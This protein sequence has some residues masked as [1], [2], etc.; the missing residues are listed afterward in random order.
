M[1]FA[2]VWSIISSL[3]RGL[4]HRPGAQTMLYLSLVNFEIQ[5]SLK[6]K[7]SIRVHFYLI[8]NFKISRSTPGVSRSDASPMSFHV[9]HTSLNSVQ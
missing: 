8:S 4:S 9:L 7:Q 1:A 3:V 2:P 6:V 5:R